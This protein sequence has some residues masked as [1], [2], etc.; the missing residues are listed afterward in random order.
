MEQ[1]LVIAGTMVVKIVLQNN[2]KLSHGLIGISITWMTAL[3][4]VIF[5]LFGHKTLAYYLDP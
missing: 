1:W 4:K 5:M 3:N 2:H